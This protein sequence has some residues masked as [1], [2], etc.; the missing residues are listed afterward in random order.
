MNE[1]KYLIEAAT[2][3][4][5]SI[6]IERNDIDMETAFRTL[7]TST[8]YAKLQ[9]ENTGLYLQSP[10]YVYDFLKDEIHCK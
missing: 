3:D 4:I 5:I 7:Y 2:K 1:A 8:T 9:Q 10:L 6:L